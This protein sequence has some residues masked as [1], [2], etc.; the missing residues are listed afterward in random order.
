MSIIC[1]CTLGKQENKKEDLNRII[2]RFERWSEATSNGTYV[3][4]V[5]AFI[6][7]LALST[8]QSLVE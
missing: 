6:M 2:R 4:A 1:H 3:V 8:R 7:L 5:A